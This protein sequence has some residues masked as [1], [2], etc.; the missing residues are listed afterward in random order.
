MNVA[1]GTWNRPSGRQTLGN[2]GDADAADIPALGTTVRYRQRQRCVSCQPLQRQRRVTYQ[3]WL[4]AKETGSPKR[5]TGLKARNIASRGRSIPNMFRAFSPLACFETH[6]L[7]LQARLAWYAPLA[8]RRPHAHA[9]GAPETPCPRR[10]RSGEP[11]PPPSS[12]RRP[13]AAAIG[14]LEDA[15]RWP[16]AGLSDHGKEMAPLGAPSASSAFFCRLPRRRSGGGM[17][18]VLGAP[19]TP[20]RRRWCFGGRLPLAVGGVI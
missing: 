13:H 6:P 17:P 7:A 16:L 8:L 12:L 15:C 4:K 19:E 3:P 18:S 11:I 5:D 10:W 2:E 1:L 9:V 20:C 14:A